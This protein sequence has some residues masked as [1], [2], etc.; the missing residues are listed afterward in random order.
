MVTAELESVA[1]GIGHDVFNLGM[2]DENDHHLT[3]IHLGIMASILI[4]S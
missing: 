2:T 4:K 1:G 3:Y